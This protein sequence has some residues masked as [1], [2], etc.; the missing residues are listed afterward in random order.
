MSP[1][2]WGGS[3]GRGPGSAG[4]GRVV[5]LL[6]VAELLELPVG[7]PQCALLVRDAP[8]EAVSEAVES[9]C[10]ALLPVSQLFPSPVTVEAVLLVQ[11]LCRCQDP[12]FLVSKTGFEFL[13]ELLPEVRGGLWSGS[14]VLGVF[15]AAV[16]FL[17]VVF[18]FFFFFFFWIRAVVLNQPGRCSA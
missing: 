5:A 9:G 2:P 1:V 18:F 16:F 3:R 15:C 12:L 14:F 8:P 4:T 7:V 17:V 13:L 10:V 6:T 11:V